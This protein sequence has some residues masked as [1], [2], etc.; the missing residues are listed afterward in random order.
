MFVQKKIIVRTSVD[1]Q[2]S[3][4]NAV[5]HAGWTPQTPLLVLSDDNRWYWCKVCCCVASVFVFVYLV[6]SRSAIVVFGNSLMTRYRLA[7]GWMKTNADRT[8]CGRIYTPHSAPLY[9]LVNKP[10]PRP[11]DSTSVFWD[12]ISQSWYGYLTYFDERD[13]FE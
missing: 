8:R 3:T 12:F 9:R 2:C 6:V 7:K 4:A 5:M 1:S 11:R 13:A 10:K